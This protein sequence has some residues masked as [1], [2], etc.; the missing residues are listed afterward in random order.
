MAKIIIAGQAVVVT[1]SLSLDD[2]KELKK[3]RPDALT[4]YE[5]EGSEKEP[6]FKVGLAC[7]AGTIG[8]YGVEFGGESHDEEKLATVTMV[9]PAAVEDV[10]EYVSDAIGAAALKL[11]QLEE[12]LPEVLE[13][14]KKERE[15]IDGIIEVIG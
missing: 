5:G 10:K 7:G 15:K 6:V 8:T 2:I 13:E 9:I 11:S 3:Y 1:S 14:I 4:L 12:A